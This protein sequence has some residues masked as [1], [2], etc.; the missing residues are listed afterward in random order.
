MAAERR[1]SRAVCRRA[2]RRGRGCFVGGKKV[3]VSGLCLREGVPGWRSKKKEKEEKKAKRGKER[4]G[5]RRIA[6]NSPHQPARRTRTGTR[7]RAGCW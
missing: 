3:L 6:R 1:E 5:P 7:T 2:G 4:S